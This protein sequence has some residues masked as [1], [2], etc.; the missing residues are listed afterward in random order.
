MRQLT[1]ALS[2]A[3]LSCASA[4]QEK[5][6]EVTELKWPRQFENAGDK[7]VVYDPQVDSWEKHEKLH[8][9]SAV[10]VTPKGA[11]QPYYGV[12]EYDVPTEVHVEARQVLLKKRTF[13]AVRFQGLDKSRSTHGEEIVRRVLGTVEPFYVS[14][15]F[16]LAYVQEDA[17]K[18][19]SITVNLE[20]P[21]I[22]V[23]HEPAV[24]VIFMGEPQLKP[25]AGTDLQYATNT[26]WDVLFHPATARYYLL[27][28]EG[29]LATSDVKQGPWE[30]AA[31]LPADLWK[32]PQD[33]NW[34]EVRK[35]L[36][37]K[38]IAVPRVVAVT[39]PSEL[40]LIEG[41]PVYAPIPGTRLASVSNTESELF[42]HEGEGNHYFLTS[43][44]WFRSKSL[45]GPWS[46]ATTDLPADFAK[47]PAD[48]PKASVRV[49]VPGTPEAADA[50]LLAAVPRKATVNRKD[51][52]VSV[53][54]E[55]TPQFVVVDGTKVVYYAVNSP[56]SVFRVGEKY[57]CCH[58]A[59][60]FESATATGPWVVCTQVPAEIYAIPP[61]HPKHTVTY[62]Y[63][64]DSTPTVV[65]VGYTGGYTGCYVS[66]GV[67]MFGVGYAVAWHHAYW[68]YHYHAHWYGYGC[69]AH[70]SWSHGAFHRSAHV[71]GPYGGA[72]YGAS[73]NPH[74]GTYSRGAYAYGPYQTR[75]RQ[76]AYNPYTGSYAAR[77]G[78]STPYSSWGQGVVGQGDDWV[79]GGYT[80]DARGTVGRA[81]SSGGGRVVAGE[82]SGG[83]S[84]FVGETGSGDVY[85][86]R[87]GEVYRKTDDGWQ[88][89]EDGTWGSVNPPEGASRPKTTER[90]PTPKDTY[91]GLERD[92]GSR[93]RG[94]ENTRQLNRS[95]GDGA[96]FR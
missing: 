93:Q 20:P 74:T 78:G 50:I 88:H 75:Y 86:G 8:A 14:L 59:V 84:G 10:V 72:G 66:C 57:Y 3:L 76:S 7:V 24:L 25:V 95:R 41:R 47:I 39:A 51:V 48:G 38:K 68:H 12:I 13:T 53:V 33:E 89:H 16:V 42:L 49:S 22:R 26:N 36:P 54:Y 58:N 40:I 1:L 79:K 31:T 44:R 23:S 5:P 6:E 52:S 34:S 46:A 19:P 21:P 90:T 17:A 63:V 71:Y 77:R 91:Q 32:L 60:W 30:P 64:Y 85:A 94:R 80:S 27:H 4:G 2:L 15:D 56:Y 28:G 70:Y 81:E 61:T 35:N 69:G 82:G 11:A 45:E 55:G 92:S 87:N 37:G 73:Y 83:R 29:W 9:R 67:V 65:V 18:V 43:G 62:V 96:R